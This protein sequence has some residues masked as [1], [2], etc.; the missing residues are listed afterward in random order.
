MPRY[1]V[2]S[3]TFL[4]GCLYDPE[5]KRPIYHADK[6]FPN[7]GKTEQVPS[8]LRRLKDETKAAKKTRVAKQNADDVATAEKQEEDAKDVA[9]VTFTG[10]GGTVETL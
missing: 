4:G 2:L 7:K 6:P 5:G 8:A 3:P 1:Q 9:E 10:T